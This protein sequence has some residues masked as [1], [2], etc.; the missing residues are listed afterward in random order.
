MAILLYALFYLNPSSIADPNAYARLTFNFSGEQRIFEG[1]VIDNMTLLDALK[2]STTA[3]DI[4]FEY[5][6]D[7]TNITHIDAINDHDQIKSFEV[8]LNSYLV[9]PEELNQTK[10]KRGDK[11]SVILR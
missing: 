7:S 10:I 5:Y 11:I 3:G 9:S 8:Y 1:E 4:R 2:A 6:V